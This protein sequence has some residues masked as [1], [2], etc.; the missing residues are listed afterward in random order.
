MRDQLGRFS[1]GATLIGR[2]EGGPRPVPTNPDVAV[3]QVMGE[4]AAR[5]LGL[6]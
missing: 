1:A 2:G 4:M 5:G 3:E 6:I